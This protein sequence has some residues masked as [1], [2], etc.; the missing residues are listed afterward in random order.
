[1]LPL[2]IEGMSS[3]VAKEGTIPFSYQGTTYHTWYKIA[4]EIQDGQPPLIALH[5][6]P[7]VSHDYLLPLS[8]LA[9][10]P[11][12]QA[13]IFYDQVGVGRSTHL[14]DKDSSLF[15]F[16]LFIA[17]LENLI[18]HFNVNEAYNLIGHSWGGILGVEFVI[19]RQLRGLRHLVLTNTLSSFPIHT[20]EVA[21][22]K[23]L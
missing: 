3:S 16:D 20:R 2:Q 4:G 21:R 1:M 9:S 23:T 17:E 15:T 13:V 6:G 5:G 18:R 22:L 7:G 10:S 11:S 14:L 12:S 19:R 8:D